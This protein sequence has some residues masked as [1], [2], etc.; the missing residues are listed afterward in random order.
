MQV[1]V[2]MLHIGGDTPKVVERSLQWHKD[3]RIVKLEKPAPNLHALASDFFS[4][5]LLHSDCDFSLI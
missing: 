5:I 2:K 4:N 1:Q 3:E